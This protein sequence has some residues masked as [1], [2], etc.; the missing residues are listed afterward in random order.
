MKKSIFVCALIAILLMTTKPMAQKKST[1]AAKGRSALSA[2]TEPIRALSGVMW[3]TRITVQRSDWIN[4]G[5]ELFEYRLASARIVNGRLEFVGSYRETGREKADVVTATLIATSARSANP[6]PSASSSTAR[7][8]RR[9]AQ[10]QEREQGEVTE[11]TQSLYSAAEVGS[12][13]ELIYLKMQP[14]KYQSPLQV[15]VVLAHLDN[16]W[17]NQIN[18]AI[19]R[20]ARA[21]KANENTDEALGKLNRLISRE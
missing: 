2:K 10:N 5:K 11:Q 4:E 8:R 3:E 14:P 20:V 16:Q 12:G 18:Q 17:G 9:A 7:D 19:C 15:G 13:C 6:W 1:P 21:L